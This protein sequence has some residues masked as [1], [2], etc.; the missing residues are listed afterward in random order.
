[1]LRAATAPNE[2]PWYRDWKICGLVMARLCDW[3]IPERSPRPDHRVTSPRP[4]EW[5]FTSIE[6]DI[7]WKLPI[8]S[9]PQKIDCARSHRFYCC[10]AGH[11]FSCFLAE[12]RGLPFSVI[13]VVFLSS[14]P[15][16]DVVPSPGHRFLHL[17]GVLQTIHYR[18]M[19]W[20]PTQHCSN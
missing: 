20:S 2:L 4:W 5:R 9:W 12:G 13:K 18:C 15:D 3:V 10:A 14:C 16:H 11:R 7:Q 17:Y 8:L 1:M 6:D 19:Q